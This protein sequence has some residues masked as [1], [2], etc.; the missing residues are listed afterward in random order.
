MSAVAI[1]SSDM[2]I[3]QGLKK[4]LKLRSKAQVIHRALE[5]L[6]QLVERERLAEQIRLSVKK[7]AIADLK[8]NASLTGGAFVNSGND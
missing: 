1:N 3:L 6:S 7:C 4:N 5:E 2:Q 8:E